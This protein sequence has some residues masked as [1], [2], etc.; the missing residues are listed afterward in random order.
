MAKVVAAASVVDGVQGPA[1][2]PLDRRFGSLGNAYRAPSNQQKLTPFP[3]ED[4]MA[5]LV[6]GGTGFIGPRAILGGSR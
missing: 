5:I 3:R 2:T 4:D 1:Y 6:I